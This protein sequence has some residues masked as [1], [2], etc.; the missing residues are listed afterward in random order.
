MDW[1]VWDGRTGRLESKTRLRQLCCVPIR[2][3]PASRHLYLLKE[4]QLDGSRRIGPRTP[5]VVA[6]D[7]TSGRVAGRLS[8]SGVQAGTWWSKRKV[9]GYRV[10]EVNN[11]GFAL[12]PDGKQL[13]VLDGSANRLYLIDA[14]TLQVAK[15]FQVGPP[16]GPLARL[17]G[18]LGLLPTVAEAKMME[19]DDASISFSPD[20]RQLY[21]TGDMLHLDRQGR[22][23]VTRLPLR[24]IDAGSG[25]IMAT[26]PV[27]QAPGDVEVAP[28]GSALYTTGPAQPQSNACPCVLRRLDPATL[29]IE[30]ERTFS[31][32]TFGQLYAL[33]TPARSLG[34]R[35]SPQTGSDT[36]GDAPRASLYALGLAATAGHQTKIVWRMTGEGDLRMFAENAA[37]TRVTPYWMQQ[38]TLGSNWNRPGDEWGTGWTFPSA[39][40]WRIFAIRDTVAGD[41]W[42]TVAPPKVVRR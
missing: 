18:W 38:H 15:T 10:P 20:G 14:A 1:Y 39:G 21:E 23:S 24:V 7:T 37:G 22:T 32:A 19:G 17:L 27:D 31:A 4:S 36:E 28:D 9:K 16:V 42:F 6:Y 33:A 8:L 2:Y 13:A 3:D 26:T 25:A 34:C 29:Q 40:C 5:V 35:L 30:A 41:A 11:L 12:S